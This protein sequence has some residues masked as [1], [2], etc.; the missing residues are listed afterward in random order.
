[1][2]LCSARSSINRDSKES[3][4]SFCSVA[5]STGCTLPTCELTSLENIWFKMYRD[6]GENKTVK[7]KLQDHMRV[8]PEKQRLFFNEKE[9]SNAYK[10]S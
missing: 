5:K 10:L 7:N 9:L 8:S 6:Y 4:A 2:T 1:M 3:F